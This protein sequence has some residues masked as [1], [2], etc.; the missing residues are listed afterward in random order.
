MEVIAFDF[1]V[2]HDLKAPEAI[3][4]RLKAAWI[5]QHHSALA[6]VPAGQQGQFADLLR[7]YALASQVQMGLETVAPGRYRLSLAP[8]T[9][10]AELYPEGTAAVRLFV[11]AELPAACGLAAGEDLRWLAVP[12]AAWPDFPRV[13]TEVRKGRR[14]PTYVYVGLALALLPWLVGGWVGYRVFTWVGELSAVVQ[15]LDAQLDVASSTISSQ[16]AQLEGLKEAGKQQLDEWQ[17]IV[18][19]TQDLIGE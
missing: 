3:A 5:A 14:T 1:E 16:A 17:R 12:D 15:E 6:L 7:R 9:A 10:L 2:G 13:D 11:Q 8:L 18:T 19:K 4:A